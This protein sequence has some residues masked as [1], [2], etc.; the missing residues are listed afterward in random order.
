MIL[1][2]GFCC[3][4]IEE[5]WV[6][7]RHLAVWDPGQWKWSPGRFIVRRWHSIQGLES[8]VLDLSRLQEVE[9]VVSATRQELQEG[10]TTAVLPPL[11]SRPFQLPVSWAVAALSGSQAAHHTRHVAWE[12]GGWWANWKCQ[13]LRPRTEKPGLL[14]LR[15]WSSLSAQGWVHI[16]WQGWATLGEQKGEGL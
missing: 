16:R 7:C 15:S 11:H 14:I 9:D 1:S 12:K 10:S 6:F 5:E 2:W 3:Y 8:K 13:V 4:K